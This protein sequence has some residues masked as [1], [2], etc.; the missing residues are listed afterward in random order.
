MTENS[1][2]TIVISRY[3]QDTGENENLSSR[4]HE[5]V[6]GVLVIDHIDLIAQL[7]PQLPDLEA[8]L[9]LD[10]LAFLVILP[11]LSHQDLTDIRT[12]AP[13]RYFLLNR[14]DLSS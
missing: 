12:S 10:I 9:P 2:E 5:S 4:G 6:L 14:T 8:Y 11:T 13:P 1:G 3:R 7:G